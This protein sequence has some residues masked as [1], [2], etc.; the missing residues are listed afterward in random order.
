M[1]Q[2]ARSLPRKYNMGAVSKLRPKLFSLRDYLSTSN[3]PLLQLNG[4]PQNRQSVN[5][6]YYQ[7]VIDVKVG[8]R[9]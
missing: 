8:L 3:I 9:M 6:T 1:L 7:I 4:N 2:G 5:R